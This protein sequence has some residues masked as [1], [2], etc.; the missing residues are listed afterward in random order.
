MGTRTCNPTGSGIGV[1]VA[2][3][4]ELADAVEGLYR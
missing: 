2:E 1:R 4:R 3:R